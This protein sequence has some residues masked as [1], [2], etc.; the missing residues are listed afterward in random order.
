MEL[1]PI[2]PEQLSGEERFI[3]T[4]KWLEFTVPDFWRWSASNLVSNA[5]RGV[6]VEFLVGNAVGDSLSIR[7]EWAEYD[8]Q[9]STAIRIEVKSASFL[10]IWNQKRLS[11]VS[12]SYKKSQSFDSLTGQLKS[13]QRRY[14]DVYVFAVLAHSNQET[15]NPLDLSQ[16][17]FYVAPT[18]LLDKR[19]WSQH[20]ISLPSLKAAFSAVTYSDLNRT[21]EMAGAEHQRMKQETM[22]IL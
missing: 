14:A 7:D 9:S 11:K 12:F 8:L 10:Q 17:E 15:L 3:N 6:L 5:T 2:I 1:G 13:E 22:E 18:T 20:S 21:V 4:A 19:L 16:W